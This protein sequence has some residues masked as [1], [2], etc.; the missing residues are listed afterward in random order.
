MQV[1]TPLYMKTKLLTAGQIAKRHHASL[2]DV[3]EWSLSIRKLF[4]V[5]GRS[6]GIILIENDKFSRLGIPVEIANMF[7]NLPSQKIVEKY[8]PFVK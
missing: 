4:D 5:W 3:Y 6:R 7:P 1:Q 8:K 2:K